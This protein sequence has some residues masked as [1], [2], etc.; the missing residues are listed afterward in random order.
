MQTWDAGS[1]VPAPYSRVVQGEARRTRAVAGPRLS[2]GLGLLF[3]WPRKFRPQPSRVHLA[4]EANARSAR[5]QGLG[6]SDSE[7]DTRAPAWPPERLRAATGCPGVPRS[8]PT[9][10]DLL[11]IFE[12]VSRGG[13]G[14]R[15]GTGWAGQCRAPLPG[16]APWSRHWVGVEKESEDCLF[17]TA[18]RSLLAPSSP[19]RRGD[20]HRGLAGETKHT[21]QWSE[22]GPGPPAAGAGTKAALPTCFPWASWRSTSL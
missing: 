10:P 16:R 1:Q 17:P 12:F 8:S 22:A 7:A 15:A 14:R 3:P 18:T 11:F 2:G 9:F 5:S 21:A 20:R 6:A 19:R 13:P 4:P